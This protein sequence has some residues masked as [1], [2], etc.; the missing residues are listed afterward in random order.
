MLVKKYLE[1]RILATK[2]S[3]SYLYWV[4]FA[5]IVASSFLHYFNG[6]YGGDLEGIGYQ[7]DGFKLS[8][9]TLVYLIGLY[10]SLYLSKKLSF[11]HVSNY[12]FIVRSR[13]LF[14]FFF[15]SFPFIV[16]FIAVLGG[17]GTIHR[18][19]DTN[20]Y[21][22]LFFALF[23][24]YI[25]LALMIYFIYLRLGE[26]LYD[27]FLLFTLVC[28]YLFLVIR[29]GFTGFLIFLLPVFFLILL[30]FF[31][32]GKAIIILFFSILLFPF[33]RIGKWFIGSGLKIEDINVEVFQAA[34][35]GVIERFSAVP[36]MVFISESLVNKDVFL[37]SNYS[38]FFQGYIGSF[39]HKL[40][41]SEPVYLNTLLL[42]QTI[43]DTD[44]D[45]NSTFPLLSYISLDVGLGLFTLLYVFVL[46]IILTCLLTLVFGKS[47]LGR[48][49]ISF[50][51]FNMVFFY[52]FNGW[53]WGLWGAIQAVLLF[54]FLLLLIGK[55]R[56]NH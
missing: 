16:L 50:F 51:L 44:S 24:P 19:V 33:I 1:N 17:V 43:Q 40:F 3:L 7:V 29:S 14:Y 23:D 54:C 20:R 21:A 4:I 26:V 2:L 49:L 46:V 47:D 13:L 35:R 39:F 5:M 32:R 22:D 31:S 45:S 48:K 41:F 9:F 36:N 56:S 11:V 25:F 6:Y 53:L 38:P 30:R 27:K 12:F 37:Q 18:D 52:A 15:F 55:L 8:I 42:H 34:I 10:G 28:I